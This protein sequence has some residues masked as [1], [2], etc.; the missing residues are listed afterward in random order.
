MLIIQTGCIQKPY[1]KTDKI[2]ICI[3]RRVRPEFKFDI[4]MQPLSPST[5][6]L[7]SYQNKIISWPE[8]EKEFTTSVLDKQKKYLK[9]ILDI[10]IKKSVVLLCWEKTS[11][12]C[13]RSLVL[14]RLREMEA[15]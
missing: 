12:R 4:Y 11:T 9:I 5:K 13:H 14:K 6:L 1:K 8:F 7:K 2:R 3:M 15:D 10:A